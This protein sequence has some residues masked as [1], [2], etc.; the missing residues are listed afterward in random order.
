V[1]RGKA[2]ATGRKPTDQAPE[3][4]GKNGKMTIDDE[5][6]RRL[7]MGA[8]GLPFVFNGLSHMRPTE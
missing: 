2:A 4:K 3:N 7:T 1:G 5:K 6:C 8:A